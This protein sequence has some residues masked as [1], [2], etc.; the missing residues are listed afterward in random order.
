MNF[1]NVILFVA[2]VACRGPKPYRD[3]AEEDEDDGATIGPKL[4]D[5][6]QDLLNFELHLF[7]LYRKH[8]IMECFKHLVLSR[9]SI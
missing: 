8:N 4:P 6:V 3:E 9:S 5:Q 2:E 1:F 7:V